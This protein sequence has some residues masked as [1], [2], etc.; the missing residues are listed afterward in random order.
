[1]INGPP[2]LNTIARPA[3]ADKGFMP[4]SSSYLRFRKMLWLSGGG[5]LLFMLTLCAGN[6]F[7]PRHRALTLP[8]LGHD[9]LAFYT[10]GRFVHEDRPAQM[11]DL[12]AVRQLQKRVIEEAGLETG[13]GFGPFWNPP[14]YALALAPLGRLPFAQALRLW[15]AAGL[16]ALLLASVLLC[17]MFPAGAGWRTRGLV[18]LLLVLSMPA[19]QAFTHG[20]NT[21]FSLLILVVAVVLW[22]TAAAGRMRTFASRMAAVGAGMAAGLLAY[23]PQVG[24]VVWVAMI[25][26][27][28][29]RALLGLA[30]TGAL[31]L[32]ATELFTPGM[33]AVWLKRLPENLA[34]MQQQRPY[35]WE[36]HVTLKAFW[37][38][39]IQQHQTGADLPLVR[40]LWGLSVLGIA[41]ALL[42]TAVRAVRQQRAVWAAEVCVP[43]GR[44]SAAWVEHDRLISAAVVASPLLVP[45]Y[46]DYDL[47]L[48]AVAPVLLAVE[49][50]CTPADQQPPRHQRWLPRMW[51]VFY[52]WLLVGPGLVAHLGVNVTTGL[53]GC[54]AVM[55]ITAAGRPFGPD[56]HREKTHE[57]EPVAMDRRGAPDNRGSDRA[58]P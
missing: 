25:L 6:L 29:W 39:L 13:G 53:L 36:R 32:G 1:M 45:F 51:V 37:R 12:D 50:T 49:R 16:V 27:L 57:T 20:Q 17:R 38:L 44:S 46:F 28:G 7:L 23:K 15:W 41:S 35:Y 4:H 56:M 33:T 47:L 8:M 5:L 3:P 21:F 48:A 40:L 2:R 18:P 30:I 31:L 34:F 14:F 22:R 43:P 58:V 10:A 26:C 55:H 9:F 52:A 54:L 24:A 42:S 19:Q 11:Y